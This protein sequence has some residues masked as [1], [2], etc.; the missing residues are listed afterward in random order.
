MTIGAKH[1]P[2]GTRER[3]ELVE[4]LRDRAKFVR[5]ET[6]RLTRIAGAGH[7]TGTFSAAELF[8]EWAQTQMISSWK[9][10]LIGKPCLLLGAGKGVH[11]SRASIGTSNF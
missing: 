6:V 7:Y 4:R 11:G 5:L 9:A 2:R 1:P 10:T 3:E 8:A